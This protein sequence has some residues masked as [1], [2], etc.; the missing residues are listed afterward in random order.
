MWRWVCGDSACVALCAWNCARDTICAAPCAWYYAMSTSCNQ[1]HL[2]GA[3][4]GP[5]A[6]TAAGPRGDSACAQDF[7]SSVA[8]K[9]GTVVTAFNGLPGTHA[10]DGFVSL[11]T[12]THMMKQ[13]LEDGA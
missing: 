9:L 6:R 4:L 11:H 3:R 5:G 12:H 7:I 8:C 2:L 13:Q 1:I 10:R